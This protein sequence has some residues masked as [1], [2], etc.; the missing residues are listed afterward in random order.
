MCDISMRDMQYFENTDAKALEADIL[1]F[2]EGTPS[3]V[4]LLF[5]VAACLHYQI[6]QRVAAMEH[7]Q[8]T[9]ILYDRAAIQ[10]LRGFES[11]LKNLTNTAT[12]VE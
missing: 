7:A 2:C 11:F 12:G 5:K 9:N 4:E 3:R 8:P 10:A 6:F 1:A